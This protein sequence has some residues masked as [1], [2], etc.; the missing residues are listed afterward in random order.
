MKTT[1]REFLFGSFGALSLSTLFLFAATAALGAVGGGGTNTTTTTGS[2]KTVTH[3]TV[4]DLPPSGG[5]AQTFLSSLLGVSYPQASL[6][7]DKTLADPVVQKAIAQAKQAVTKSGGTLFADATSNLVS[8]SATPVY[9]RTDVT[10]TNVSATTTM[11]IGPQTIMVGDNQSQSFSIVPGGVDYDTLITTDVYRNL[12]YQL[13][14][15]T[16]TSD[17]PGL[18]LIGTTSA[19]QYE[20]V[21]TAPIY[22][23]SASALPVV[24]YQRR[25]LLGVVGTATHDVNG[26][27]F[28]LRSDAQET[29]PPKAK[30][31]A[32]TSGADHLE[33]FATG[34]FGA[35]DQDAKGSTPGFD[36]RTYAG[37]VGGEYTFSPE[38]KFGAAGTA[39]KNES[40]LGELG[41]LEVSGVELSAYG[42]WTRGHFYVD[43]LYGLGLYKDEIKRHTL[44]GLTA[45]AKP[46]AT[47]HTLN[48]NTGYN[49]VQGDGLVTGPTVGLAYTHGSLDGYTETGGGTANV[50]VESQTFESLITDVGWQVSYAIPVTIGRLTFQGRTSWQRENLSDDSSVQVG[51]VQSPYLMVGPAG[52]FTRTDSFGVSAAPDSA[53]DNYWVLGAGVKLEIGKDAAVLLDYEEHLLEHRLRERFVS[54]YGQIRF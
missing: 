15:T 43:G 23:L 49:F 26:R 16:L 44:I 45:N 52:G 30:A 40:H 35:Q 19:G 9:V 12:V 3:D 42:S 28:R 13:T 46:S 11:Y 33:W 14:G 32:S 54:L 36:S 5:A 6:T 31:A 8:G 48:L 29:V 24:L 50:A 51:L 39:L 41:H 37:T 4:V 47:T 17:V 34:D 22:S 10:A 7:T 38:L 21:D 1:A 25:A 53:E 20:V 27:L 2:T 18:A